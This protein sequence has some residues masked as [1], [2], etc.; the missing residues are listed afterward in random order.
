VS[1]E[2]QR[3]P[4]SEDLSYLREVLDL[5]PSEDAIEL[6][7]RRRA[8][9]DLTHPPACP[10][11]FAQLPRRLRASALLDELRDSIRAADAEA[12]PDLEDALRDVCLPDQVGQLER[13]LCFWRERAEFLALR[14]RLGDELSEVLE[15]VWLGQVGESVPLAESYLESLAERPEARRGLASRVALLRRKLPG[16]AR[17]EPELLLALE[18]RTQGRGQKNRTQ[19]TVFVLVL[20]YL[21][22]QA[23]NQLG[24]Q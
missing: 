22:L 19:L 7:L 21:L 17:L 20:I 24:R 1:L 9:L 23:I 16:L 5:D 11:P 12:I 13:L 2:P 14:R 15:G 8:R 3:D 10:P 18:R 6:T 4:A